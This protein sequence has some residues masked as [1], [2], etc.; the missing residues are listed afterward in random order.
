MNPQTS[1]RSR[2]L[3]GPGS[4]LF[5]GCGGVYIIIFALLI[6]AGGQL[7]ALIP[8]GL[9]P[10]LILF[11]GTPHLGATLLRVY[12]RREDRRAYALVSLWFT[13]FIAI[14]FVIGVYDLTV[15]SWLVTAYLLWTPWHFTAQNYGVALMF[16]GRRGVQVS[17]LAKR[18]V[19][20]S[21]TLS[22][23]IVFLSMSGDAQSTIYAPY[24]PTGESYY[25]IRLG[26]PL[27]INTPLLAVALVGH[28]IC[29]VGALV[30]LRRAGS[31]SDLAP[32]GML[33]LVQALWFTIPVL[34]RNLGLFTHLDPFSFQHTEYSLL[35][36]MFGHSIQYLWI[37]SYFVKK[38]GAE[39]RR[40]PYLT[41][42]LLAGGACL[43]VPLLLFGP[44]LLGVRAVDAGLFLLVAAAVNIHHFVLDGV[45]WKLSNKRIAGILMRARMAGAEPAVPTGPRR[46]SWFRPLVWTAGGVYALITIV[47]TLEIEYGI[48]PALAS[49]DA[50][51]LRAAADRLYWI[52]RDH[53][54]I[55]YNLGVFAMRAGDLE[56]G[57]RELE[58][59]LEIGPSALAWTA[60]GELHQRGGDSREAFAAYDAALALDPENV[61]ALDQSAYLWIQLGDLDRAEETISRAIALAPERQDLRDTLEEIRKKRAAPE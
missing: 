6:A 12:E 56:T 59:S 38:T 9:L 16:L 50:P 31:W 39:A 32:T 14:V 54:Q 25:F 34:A 26:L 4:D 52:G 44:D 2:W 35:W 47:G 49:L 1:E 60:M 48:R 46:R 28:L 27:F 55:R 53:P 22:W 3:I 43:G 51:R 19:F 40:M 11:S 29:L 33:I 17:P 36:I 13:G 58:R 61:L 7:R 15:G 10:I 18:F 45:I 5:L 42:T 21:F 41:K 57:R 24:V 8:L 37:T 23:V 30:T 20:W